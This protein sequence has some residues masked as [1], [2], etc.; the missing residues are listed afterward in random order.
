MKIVYH[1]G[2]QIGFDTIVKKGTITD[3]ES[4]ISI[5][6][7]DKS[8]YKLNNIKEVKFVKINALGTMI[9]LTNGNDVIYLTVPRIFIDKGTGFIIVNYFATKKLGK[10]LM[11]QM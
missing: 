6:G 5:I 8:E 10:L 1:F 11:E 4:Q 9:R 7:S 2:N 3:A